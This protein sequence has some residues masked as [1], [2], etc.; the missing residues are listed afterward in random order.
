M[1]QNYRIAFISLG[2]AKNLVDTEYMMGQ[3]RQIGHQ[4][5]EDPEKAEIIVV[6]TCGFIDSAK[7]E[8][9]DTLLDMAEFKSFGLQWLIATGCLSQRY[10]KELQELLP[11]VD[12]FLGSST[13]L[14]I[15]RVI[16]RLDAG[17]KAILSLAE[18]ESYLPHA[19]LPKEQATLGATAYLKIAD[20]CSN[21]CSYCTIPLIRGEFRS[22]SIDDLKMEASQMVKNGVREICLIAQDSSRYGLDI[23]G[24]LSLVKLCRELLTLKD[25]KWL[26]IL[27]C[28]PAHLTTDLWELMRDEKRVLPYLDIPLQ[29][30]EDRILQSMHRRGS[31]AEINVALQEARKI[32][33][34]IIIRTTMIVGYPSESEIEFE[35]L[36]DFVAEQRF[37]HLGAFAY[38]QEEDTPAG[39]MTLQI[40]EDIKQE[41]VDRL[42][43]YQQ[44]ITHTIKEKWLNTEVE[45]LVESIQVDGLRLGRFWG[46]APDVDGFIILENCLADVGQF[47]KARIK[48]I[49]GYDLVAEMI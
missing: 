11:E 40:E 18:P 12:A 44:M 30:S 34:E 46:Q 22:R 17:E 1:S 10:G 15:G 6:N 27:Y 13:Y 47:V 24:E 41:R 45:V 28:Y 3:V 20:G 25:L 49:Q 4:L 19:G 35:S 37:D 21:R 8:A 9:I 29:H 32:V 16:E 42:M 38:S 39:I 7:Q 5:V 33:P 23:Y 2:C 36:L 26:R 14:E 43:K 31:K 48:A